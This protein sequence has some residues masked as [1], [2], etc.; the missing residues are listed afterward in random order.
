MEMNM[1]YAKEIEEFDE[2]VKSELDTLKAVRAFTLEALLAARQRIVKDE[3][4]IRQHNRELDTLHKRIQVKE[5]LFECSLRRK[6]AA[7]AAAAK[8]KREFKMRKAG[9]E[10]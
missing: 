1:N 10:N 8:P 7:A 5:Y 3:E 6:A 2:Q 9:Q 4:E